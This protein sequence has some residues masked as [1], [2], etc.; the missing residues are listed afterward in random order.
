MT[1]AA[2]D[3]VEAF[4]NSLQH[5]LMAGIDLS[6]DRM[7]RLLGM[8]GQPQTRLPPV[9][10]VAG[11][12]GKGSLLAYLTAIFAAAGLRVHRYTSPHLVEFR[13]RMLVRGEMVEN[14][15]LLNVMKHMAPLLAQQPVTFFEATTALAYV[16]FA[17]KPADILLLETGMGGRLDA[18]NV[19]EKPLVTA[20]TPV[21][22]DHTE[23]LGE[24][25]EVIAGEKAGIMKRGVPCVIGRQAP[26]IMPVL[27]KKAAALDVPL[28][29]FGQEF[30]IERDGDKRWYRSNKRTLELTPSLPGAFQYDNAA[31]ALACMDAQELYAI[32]G[33]HVSRGLASAQWPARLQHLTHHPYNRLAGAGISLYLDGGH[34]PQGGE[35]LA[36][37]LKE[38]VTP[39]RYLICGMMGTK[40]CT[41]YLRPLA[42]YVRALY[43]VP[44]P[45]E[46]NAKPPAE[47]QK[48]AQSLGIEAE[49]APSVEIALQTIARRAKTPAT[50][51][52]CGSLY[53]AGKVL[54]AA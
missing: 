52:I 33:A 44:I 48:A 25:L 45:G 6:L 15:T 37:W 9:I 10:H 32:E 7:R 41:S 17:E 35:M 5:P 11:T 34:N 51:C 36:Q 38:Q 40:D 29:R 53:L 50:L 1:G 30:H 27:E 18:T 54:A 4:L 43:A 42:P 16:V 49:M 26:E 13:E 8:M 20:I 46:A 23:F 31:C 14:D 2:S 24:S 19:I 21:S 39:E 3:P 47:V 28:I 12:N 22:F